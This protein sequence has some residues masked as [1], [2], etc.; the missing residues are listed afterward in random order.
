MS[1][2]RTLEDA[3]DAFA[4]LP[5]PVVVFNKSHSGSRLL[6][7]LL[8]SS[9]IWMGGRLNASHDA[10]G[11][12]PLVRHVVERYYP[13]YPELW[14]SGRW[15]DALVGLIMD[16][17]GEH[18]DGRG[19]R[20]WGWKL[21]ET[22]YLLPLVDYLFPEARYIHI[23]RDGRDVAFSDHVPPVEPLWRKIYVDSDRVVSWRGLTFGRL[24]RI[25]YRLDSSRYNM[26][27]WVNSVE[28][29]RRYGAMLG[30]R[31]HEVR[32]EDLC[33]DFDRVGR[34]VL[35]FAQA[36]DPEAGLATIGPTVSP[37]SIGKFRRRNPLKVAA[38]TRYARPLLTSLGYTD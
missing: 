7:R 29:G 24:A 8:E 25:F 18:L 26:Q 22:V 20:P 9:G 3:R 23:I 15:D 21:C 1:K 10:E 33:R 32:Y 36:L 34:E 11:L 31:Y 6:A 4:G 37:S 2:G 16:V 14:R 19:D 12:F 35:R 38:V 28:L 27:H 30:D 5:P 17:F 13:D